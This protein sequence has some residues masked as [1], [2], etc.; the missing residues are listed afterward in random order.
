M[1]AKHCKCGV[2]VYTVRIMGQD[3]HE[4]CGKC[5]V[6]VDMCICPPQAVP[7]TPPTHGQ[8]SWSPIP[9]CLRY[10]Y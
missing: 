5:D 10:G 2:Q 3:V 9:V 4:I 7:S 8:A 1:Q 6:E